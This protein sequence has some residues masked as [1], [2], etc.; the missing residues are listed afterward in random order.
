MILRSDLDVKASHT[1]RSET[2]L[3]RGALNLRSSTMLV[4]FD[5]LAPNV[6]TGPQSQPPFFSITEPAI[7]DWRFDLK[8]SGDSFMRVRSPYFK[9]QLT[10][11]F[12]LGGTFAEPLLIG[13]VR[14]VEGELR[15]PGAKM[16][17]ASGEAFIEPAQ[18]NAVQLNFSGIAQ[19]TS[20]I[21]T[22]DV[23]Q[24]LADPLIQFQSTPAL[25][26]AAIVRL[27]TTGSTTGGGVGTVGLYLG[28]GLLGAGG[29][30]ETLADRLTVDVGEETSRSGRNTVGVRFDLSEDFFLEG[31]Y[32]VYDAYNMDLIWSIFKR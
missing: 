23:S 2:P 1:N 18:P 30:D 16:R 21:I 27:L 6:E 8:V 7:A 5:P 19:K 29:M 9:T 15:F 12:D 13:S 11:N 32:D 10:A 25:S 24:T 17:I 3:I 14:T 22:M 20:Y 28:Q 26:N 4:E 31:G